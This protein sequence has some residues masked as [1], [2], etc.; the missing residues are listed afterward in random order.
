M[1]KLLTTSIIVLVALLAVVGC[2]MDPEENTP[3]EIAVITVLD[4]P[5]S[6]TPL[7]STINHIVS[8]TISD[9][10]YDLTN[11][12]RIT[13]YFRATDSLI[14]VY[15]NSVSAQSEAS[16]AITFNVPASLS[17]HPSIIKPYQ[18]YFGLTDETNG[19]MVL[20]ESRDLIYEE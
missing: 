18:L 4:P 2:S 8:Y 12:Y 17:S 13:G 20:D 11:T 6:G 19:I 9:D 3:E 10:Y 16:F 7:P 5:A 14:Q 15:Q 1:K